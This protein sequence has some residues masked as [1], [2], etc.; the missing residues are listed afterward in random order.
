MGNVRFGGNMQWDVEG[1][2]GVSG[3]GVVGNGIL[4]G[5]GDFEGGGEW[6]IGCLMG[7]GDYEGGVQLIIGD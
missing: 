1:R 4:K 2:K 6:A 5:D 3:L 7:D